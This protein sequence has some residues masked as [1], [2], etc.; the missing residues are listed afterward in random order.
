MLSTADDSNYC[1]PLAYWRNWIW[2][3]LLFVQLIQL[4]MGRK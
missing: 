4:D 1:W 3:M 2:W